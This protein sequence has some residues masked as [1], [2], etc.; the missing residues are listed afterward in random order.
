VSSRPDSGP[1]A[2]ESAK[3][4]A[5]I[6]KLADPLRFSCQKVDIQ[7][8]EDYPYNPPKMK[9][10]TKVWHPNVSSQTGAICLDIL[11]KEWRYGA[12]L[13]NLTASMELICQF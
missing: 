4:R 3:A 2:R 10:D 9:F 13:S 8:D 7:L 5:K 12:A 1:C 11:K 6:E